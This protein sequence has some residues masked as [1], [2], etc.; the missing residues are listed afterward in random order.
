MISLVTQVDQG[1]S[2]VGSGL[3]KCAPGTE[4]SPRH[5]TPVV[6]RIYPVPEA[7]F[8]P[9]LEYGADLHAVDLAGRTPLRILE[10]MDDAPQALVDLLRARV[11]RVSKAD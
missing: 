9:A 6:G 2:G 3:A 11:D 5:E 1:L 7:E 10:D 4:A 8:R